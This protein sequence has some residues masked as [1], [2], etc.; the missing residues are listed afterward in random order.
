MEVLKAMFQLLE[1]LRT[2]PQR[3]AAFLAREG[4]A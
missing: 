4:R 2:Q 3:E 1:L